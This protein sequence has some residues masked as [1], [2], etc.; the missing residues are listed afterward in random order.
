M[1][2]FILILHVVAVSC[3]LGGALYERVIVVGNMRK[4]KGK[5]QEVMMLKAM[6]GN[7]P[8][9]LSTVIIVLI[10]GIL[11]TIMG[12]YGFLQWSWIGLKQYIMIALLITFSGYI[13]PEMS[14]IGKQ[15]EADLQQGKTVDDGMRS[16][17]DRLILYSDI[18]HIGVLLN[19]VLALTKFF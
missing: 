15:L 6:F 4:G 13:G 10:T 8:F 3:W 19:V 7:T 2:S 5:D 12:N 11:M 16:K 1:F 18:G 14:K 9:F 17:V